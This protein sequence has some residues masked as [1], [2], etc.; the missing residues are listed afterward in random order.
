MNLVSKAGK[1]A[2]HQASS[3]GGIT[4]RLAQAAKPAQSLVTNTIG[5]QAL[6]ACRLQNVVWRH[7]VEEK[8]Q[9]IEPS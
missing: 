6:P 5:S 3:Q 1:Q 2:A 8:E 7:L 4:L 9:C